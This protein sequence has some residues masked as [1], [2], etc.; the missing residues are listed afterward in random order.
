MNTKTYDCGLRLIHEENDTIAAAV[1]KI[2]C[3]VGG[4]DEDDSNRGIAHL[5]EHMFFKG[6]KTRNA[7]QINSTFD[8]LGVMINAFTDF[9]RTCFHAQGLTEHLSTIFDVMS[10]CLYNS[11]F[12]AKELAKEKTV[13]CSELEMYE[14][15]FESVAGTNSIIVGLQGTGYDYVLG[16][17][18]K[19]VSRLQTEDLLA[20]RDKWYTPNRIVV[21]VCGNIDF[22][23]VD[24]LVQEYLILPKFKTQKPISFRKDCLPIDIKT[25]YKFESKNTD[26]VYC[27]L[28]FRG[29]NKSSPDKYAFNLARLCLGSTSTSRLFVKLREEYGLVYVIGTAPCL[30]GDCGV[31]SINFISSE[32]NA[33]QVVELIKE[34]IQD[35][36]ENGFTNDEL[37]TFKN[38]CK[39]SLV[40]SQQ[41]ISARASRNGEVLIY[42]DSDFDVNYELAQI[43]AVALEEMNAA[44]N[45]Y[46]DADY[47]TAS[48]VSKTEVVDVLSIFG[49]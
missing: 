18:V 26:Q 27:Y 35:I 31:N 22:G 34:T 47:L 32:Q 49:V 48:V 5:L 36:R 37:K 3:L 23:T 8:K 25:R 39:S 33:K 38:I 4:R 14:N 42:N 16:G 30:F 43:D 41:T 45:K 15:D 17:T 10:D 2:Y 46:F 7:H 11:V 9:D 29:I 40:L 20:F 1:V 6:T 13:V 28:N 44:F 12:D 24:K 19:S 21:S